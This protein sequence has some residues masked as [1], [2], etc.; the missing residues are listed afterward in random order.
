MVKEIFR[1]TLL[2]GFILGCSSSSVFERH[3]KNNECDLAEKE[4]LNKGKEVSIVEKG[5]TVVGSTFSYA[6]TGVGYLTDVVLLVGKEV[7]V[8]MLICAPV[9]AIEAAAKGSGNALGSCFSNIGTSASS[10]PTN[11]GKSI[12]NKTESWRCSD[13]SPFSKKVRKLSKCY[14]EKGDQQKAREYL[15]QLRGNPNLFNCI[16]EEEQNKINSSLEALKTN[17]NN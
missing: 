11:L 15:I 3:I 16:S 17:K 12:Y 4:F 2:V 1:Y 10:M 7:G 14:R 13:L 8:R 6:G 5:K 9:G